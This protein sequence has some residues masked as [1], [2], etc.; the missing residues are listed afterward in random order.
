MRGLREGQCDIGKYELTKW[1]FLLKKWAFLCRSYL[2]MSHIESQQQME[3]GNEDLP[4]P[5]R[6]CWINLQL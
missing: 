2:P 5:I 4:V 3:A 1:P 6:Q